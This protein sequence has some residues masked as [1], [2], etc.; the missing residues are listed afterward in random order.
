VWNELREIWDDLAQPIRAATV[1]GQLFP[2]TPFAW[3]GTPSLEHAATWLLWLEEGAIPSHYA[4]LVDA[5]ATIWDVGSGNAQGLYAASS[6][7]AEARL[8]AWLGAWPLDTI[9][10][11]HL[12]QRF[13][14][15]ERWGAFPLPIP[16]RWLNRLRDSARGALARDGIAA[17]QSARRSS[18]T[19]SLLSIWAVATLEWLQEHSTEASSA[20]AKTLW[21]YLSAG[22]AT[23][24][25]RLVPP[26]EPGDIFEQARPRPEDVLEWAR[27]QYL[28]WRMW[29]VENGGEPEKTR[30]AEFADK[31]GRWLLGF[32]SDALLGA[33]KG[34]LSIHRSQTLRSDDTSQVTLWVIADGLGIADAQTLWKYL[35]PRSERLSIQADEAAFAALPTITAFAKPALRYGAAPAQAL[36]DSSDVVANSVRREFDISGHRDVSATLAQAQPGDL[37]V[38]KPLEPDKTYHETADISLTRAAVDGALAALAETLAEAVR[39]APSELALRLVISTDHGRLLNHSQRVHTAPCDFAP[40]GRAATSQSTLSELSCDAQG[41]ARDEGSQTVILD[42]ERFGLPQPVAIALDEGSFRDNAGRG[43]GENFP[44]GGIFPEEVVVPWLYLARDAAQVRVEARGSGRARPGNSGTL[45]LQIV[46][47]N[48][49]RLQVVAI[50]LQLSGREEQT[51]FCE[52]TVPAFDSL[53]FERVLESWPS[54]AAARSAAGRVLLRHPDGREFLATLALELDSDELQS[55]ENILDD[56]F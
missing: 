30:V 12:S 24:L 45:Q 46:N 3:D 35:E 42:P 14:S 6:E 18:Q 22:E 29:Q 8:Q 34:T 27:S 21:P 31:F 55:R 9:E 13:A 43:G 4:P 38:W 28:P 49:L 17:W 50:T 32:Y 16:Q 52:E 53:N 7:E 48:P 25:R 33:Y 51:L 15:R 26:V 47:P 11:R 44:H 54:G 20:V 36:D 19:S 40:H 1:L 2:Q 10:A 5:Q 41:I 23:Q 39:A 37:I 56:L